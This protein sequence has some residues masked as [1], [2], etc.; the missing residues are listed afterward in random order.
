MSVRVRNCRSVALLS[1]P[2][3]GVKRW[4]GT[5][6]N[7]ASRVLHP[8]PPA[9]VIP[10]NSVQRDSVNYTASKHGWP[11]HTDGEDPGR[12]SFQM[13]F[14]PTFRRA[15]LES[16]RGL[17]VNAIHAMIHAVPAGRRRPAELGFHGR[18]GQFIPTPTLPTYIRAPYLRFS[19]GVGMGMQVLAYRACMWLPVRI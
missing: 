5:Q 17:P 18:P 3:T 16:L 10:S 9:A 1:V 19:F 2:L 15:Q 11:V 12:K 6:S 8:C 13:S 4:S 7:V 14:R